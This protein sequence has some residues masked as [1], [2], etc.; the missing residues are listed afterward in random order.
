M[1]HAHATASLVAPRRALASCVRAYVVRDTTCGP[2]LPDEQ[3]FNHFPASTFCSLNWFIEGQA[4]EVHDGRPMPEPVGPLV[5]RGPQTAPTVSY[6]PGPVRG[7]KL[8]MFPQ[9]LHALTGIDMARYT[10]RIVPIHDVLGEDWVRMAQTVMQAPSDEQ[11]VRVIEHFLLPR[12]QQARQQGRAPGNLWSDCAQALVVHAA[13]SGWGRSAR[14]LERRIKTW[15]GQPLRSV[16]RLDRA[17]QSFV[18]DRKAVQSGDASWAEFALRGGYADQA[19]MCRETRQITG[20]SPAEL[21]RKAQH[22]ERY[23]VYR[24][25]DRPADADDDA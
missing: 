1:S 11:R 5:F 22:D 6:N 12:W 10:D 2:P 25:W 13:A 21:L 15:A 16:R 14:S 19:H 20:Q 3:R 23:W 9:A 8:L 4:H 7:F 18:R 24:I 17:E